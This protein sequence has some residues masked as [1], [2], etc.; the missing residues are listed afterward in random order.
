MSLKSML[1]ISLLITFSTSQ[2]VN[3]LVTSLLMYEEG[4]NPKGVCVPYIDSEGYP[5]IGYGQLCS[6]T[7][8]S[9]QAQ[10]NSACSKYSE[11]CSGKKAKQWLSNEI[12]EKTSC[13]STNANIKGA[14]NKA[15]NY[16]KA[17]LISMAYQLGCG[18]LAGFT[19]TLSL[20][21]KGDW[22]A[23]S[24][25]MLNSKWARQTPNRAK[26]HSVVIK[27]NGCGDF[28]KDYGW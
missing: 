7:K 8:V 18:G 27:T 20:M 28:C 6:S 17:I 25:E 23:A 21:A 15:S 1:F 11:N 9:T 22:S 14:Y 5:T 3:S 24:L 13:V 16:R 10:C 2:T 19:N 12:S 26:R 4:T